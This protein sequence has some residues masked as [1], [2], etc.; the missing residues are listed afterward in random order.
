VR[1]LEVRCGRRQRSA[2]HAAAGALAHDSRGV[3]A[4][5]H[6]RG[7]SAQDTARATSGQVRMRVLCEC[8]H[9]TRSQRRGGGWAAHAARQARRG[10]AAKCCSVVC[11]CWPRLTWHRQDPVA[12]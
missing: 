9:A 2:A 1:C 3:C 7:A 8:G 10:R 5:M 12:G 4:C 6:A 11:A